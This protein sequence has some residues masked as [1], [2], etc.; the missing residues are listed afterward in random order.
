MKLRPELA[1]IVEGLLART[2]KGDLIELDALG[3]AVGTMTIGSDEI[4]AMLTM[5]EG[6]GR[7]VTTR[8]GGGG[9][10]ALKTVLTTARALRAELGRAPRVQEIATRAGLSEADVQHALAL[11]SIMQ[12]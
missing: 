11:A 3:E 7:R 1:A 2:K 4:D 6:R 12:R 10:A 9:E 5:L 8:K